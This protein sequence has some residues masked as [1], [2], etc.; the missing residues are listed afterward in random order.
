MFLIIS[1]QIL[2]AQFQQEP[3]ATH[4]HLK[5]W[6]QPRLPAKMM[7]RRCKTSPGTMKQT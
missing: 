3:E 7:Q 4:F 5:R 1:M 6:P 2:E